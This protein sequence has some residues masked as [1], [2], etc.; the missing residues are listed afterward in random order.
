MKQAVL[1][2]LYI[3]LISFLV[4][5]CE[6]G[7]FQQSPFFSSRFQP[8]K[9][10][11]INNGRY[12]KPYEILGPVSYKLTKNTSVFVDQLEL[13]NEAIDSLKQEAI[14]RYGS[15]VDAIVD[16]KVNENLV[17]GNVE[18]NVTLVQGLAI[19]FI[20]SAKSNTKPKPK[21][22]P[23][24]KS[25]AKPKPIYHLEPKPRDINITPSEILK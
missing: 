7:L 24:T 12:D 8:T 23:K 3:F 4:T 22:R 11:L 15:A 9:Q 1:R 16:V 19:A 17:Q 5:G 20:P 14:A 10:V 18:E 13:R 2:L 6:S 21:A 25:T